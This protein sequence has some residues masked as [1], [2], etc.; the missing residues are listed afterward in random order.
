MKNWWWLAAMI[1]VGCQ[2]TT[3]SP[4][5]ENG[6][7]FV[8]DAAY[9][10]DLDRLMTVFHLPKVAEY[11]KQIWDQPNGS[12]MSKLIGLNR[13]AMNVVF[14]D[15]GHNWFATF[16]GKV[17][18]KVLDHD[19]INNDTFERIRGLHPLLKD[20]KIKPYSRRSPNGDAPPE[21]PHKFD[22]S[23]AKGQPVGHISISEAGYIRSLRWPRNLVSMNSKDVRPSQ[24]TLDKYF[25]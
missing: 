23:D 8:P 11:H 7:S 20:L 12:H 21:R 24:E 18:R 2:G 9:I 13:S 22:F 1:V 19:E 3:V 5:V 4:S 10:E 25:R 17:G 15:G 14:T 16:D 6:T